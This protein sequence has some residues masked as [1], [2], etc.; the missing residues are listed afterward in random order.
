M[1]LTFHRHD[2]KTGLDEVI[3]G[4]IVSMF[5]TRRNHEDETMPV[6]TASLSQTQ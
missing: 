5:L 2:R 6:F 1:I 4:A 3:M